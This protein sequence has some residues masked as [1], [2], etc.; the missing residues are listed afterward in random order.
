MELFLRT[1]I[2]ASFACCVRASVLSARQSRYAQAHVVVD[3]SERD[4]FE[5]VEVIAT[6]IEA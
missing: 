1:T 2:F 4:P 5:I 6:E 3:T